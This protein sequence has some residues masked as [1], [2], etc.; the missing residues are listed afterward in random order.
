MDEATFRSD[1]LVVAF[2]PDGRPATAFGGSGWRRL[3]V[4][5]A[6][7]FFAAAVLEDGRVLL[8]GGYGDSVIV[9]PAN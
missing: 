1:D 9:L 6:E 7:S 4:G 3:D 8:G 2:T 5:N